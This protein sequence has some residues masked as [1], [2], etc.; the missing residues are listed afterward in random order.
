VPATLQIRGLSQAASGRPADGERSLR[1]SL[2]VRREALPAGHW[3]IASSQSILGEHLVRHP[4]RFAEAEPLLRG[5][6]EGLRAA[7]GASDPRTRTALTRLI[8]FYEA[9]G[10][11]SEAARLRTTQ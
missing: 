5:G 4:R 11:P 10:R 3:L 8:A 1:E 2:A 9:W 6:Y 7:L